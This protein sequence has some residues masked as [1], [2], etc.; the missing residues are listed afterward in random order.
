[1]VLVIES[2]DS[3][4]MLLR[5]SSFC[6]VVRISCWWVVSFLVIVVIVVVYGLI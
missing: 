2:S 4:L 5:L 1:M 6:D 3:A